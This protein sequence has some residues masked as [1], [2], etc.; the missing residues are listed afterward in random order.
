MTTTTLPLPTR[1]GPRAA[2]AAQPAQPIQRRAF[3]EFIMGMPISLHVKAIDTSLTD[4]DQAAGNVFATLRKV[5][6]VFSLWR[7][8]SEL[9]RLQAGAVLAG[10]CHPW[11][12]EVLELCL[13]AEERT[14]GLFTA[15]RAA[16]G[17]VPAYDPTGVVKGW[18]I[19][20]AAA[21]LRLVP[22]ISF[23]LN[24][25]GDMV[26]GFGTGMRGVAPSWSIGIEDPHQAGRIAA[27]VEVVEGAVA[28]SGTAARG[29]HIADPRTGE[30][31][32]RSGSTTVVGPDLVW[33]DVWATAAFVDPAAV[34]DLMTERAPE[35]SLTVL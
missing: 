10:E 1:P 31:V 19:E 32:S 29:S 26:V 30:V 24:A 12:A 25:G 16:P 21:L 33:A 3:V 27:T 9:R 13:G 18:A 11:Q 34:R 28:T 20:Q 35:S 23:C 2:R 7:A 15:W 14:G 6:E 22:G 5:D 8:D 17:E 4:I